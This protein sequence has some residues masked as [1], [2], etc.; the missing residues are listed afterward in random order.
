[1]TRRLQVA[2]A[3]AVVAALLTWKVRPFRVTDTFAAHRSGLLFWVAL[4]LLVGV[5]VGGRSAGPV[6]AALL[7]RDL[8]LAAAG[9]FV[10]A[11]FAPTP[12]AVAVALLSLAALLAQLVDR[13]PWLLGLALG[14][15][16]GSAL[17][18]L[19]D[20]VAAAVCVAVVVTLSRRTAPPAAAA[21]LLVGLVLM[22]VPTASTALADDHVT[23]GGSKG[24]VKAHVKVTA[25]Q[26]L[27]VRATGRV[28]FLKGVQSDPNGYPARYSGCGGPGMCG[29]LIGRIDDAGAPFL[30]GS[31][32]VV[33]APA[34]GELE[35]SVNDYDWSDNGGSFSVTVWTTAA[36]TAP[37]GRGPRLSGVVPVPTGVPGTLRTVV[38]AALCAGAGAL[39]GQLL[40]RRREPAAAA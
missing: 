16:A 40:A 11:A 12:A 35:L 22:S 8:A 24:F 13:G 33:S 37:Q 3:L 30:L 27:H 32:G 31:A 18:R 1:M 2:G 25:G 19:I 23:V 20:L 15:A 4:G 38:L 5:L 39:G 36:G 26:V 10:V 29:T 7:P 6:K 34:A 9:G 17:G 21:L 14:A 28:T